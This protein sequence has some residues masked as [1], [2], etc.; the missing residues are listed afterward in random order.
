[1]KKLFLAF[2]SVCLLSFAV[3]AQT[4]DAAKAAKAAEKEAKAKYK[5]LQTENIESALKQVG[6]TATE[7]TAF[8]QTSKEA[9]D[10]SS[11]VRKN[12]TL[13]ADDKEAQL[14]EIS[15]EK[16]EKLKSILGDEKYRAYGKIRREQKPAEEAIVAPYKQ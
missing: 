1:M 15:A 11:V 14:K 13:S 7:I 16:N 8:K 10:K 9:S 2:L 4:D 12:E 5:A 6:A 3:T